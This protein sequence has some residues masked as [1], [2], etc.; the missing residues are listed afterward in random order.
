M[1]CMYIIGDGDY[2]KIELHRERQNLHLS[3]K[4]SF[5][6]LKFSLFFFF[7]KA[8]FN[9]FN[10]LKNADRLLASLSICLH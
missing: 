3:R 10:V 8:F 2:N 5:K 1:V 4:I 7:F 6:E 9:T